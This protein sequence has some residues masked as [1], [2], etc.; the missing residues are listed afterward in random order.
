MKMMF[1]GLVQ[2]PLAIGARAL[3]KG[4]A[5]LG[6]VLK[7]WQPWQPPN[8]GQANIQG[9]TLVFDGERCVWSHKDRATADHANMD[10]VLKIAQDTVASRRPAASS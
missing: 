9:G 10:E 4:L 7:D 2:T 6:G 5:D 8:K 1:C 3:R